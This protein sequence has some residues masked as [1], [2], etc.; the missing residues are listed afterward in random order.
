MVLVLEGN[1]EIGA[2]IRSNLCFLMF[3][4]FD[5]IKGSD[6]SYFFTMKALSLHACATCSELPS[7]ISIMKW[8]ELQIILL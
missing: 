6:K 5:V 2:H 7:N 8:I 1:T 3:K 4:A